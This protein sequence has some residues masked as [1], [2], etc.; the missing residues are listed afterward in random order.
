MFRRALTTCSIVV[1]LVAQALSADD[2]PEYRLAVQLVQE[3]RWAEALDHIQNLR[4]QYPGNPKV[5]NLE[6]LALLGRGDSGGAAAAFERVLVAHPGF[7]P[8]IKN[9]AILEWETKNRRAAEHTVQA[10]KMEPKDPVLNVYGALSALEQK[11]ASA[12]NRH[13]DLAGNAISAMPPQLEMRL[14]YL[15][16]T[17]GSYARAAHVYEDIV[18]HG[19]R[20]PTLTY[21]FGLAQYLGGDYQGAIH[22]LEEP[23][24]Q[25]QSRDELNLLAQAYEKNHQTQLA[26]DRLR[27]A[28][29]RFPSDENN[30]LDLATICIDHN[31]YP[32]GIQ[33]V[34]LGLKSNPGSKKLLF[35]LGVLHALSG[36]FDVARDEFRIVRKLAP[37]QD[38][39]VAAL[40]LADI[41]QN[42]ETLQEL[43]RNLK[44]KGDSAILCY[45]LGSS[46]VRKGARRGTPEYAE[47]RRCFQ[48]AIQLDPKLPYPYIELGKMYEQ[49]GKIPEAISLFEKVTALGFRD[50]APYY[51]LAR[52]YQKLN[53][54]QKAKQMLKKL[55]E[56][57]R[58][59]REFEQVG[60][61]GPE[62]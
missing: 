14:A 62:A 4:K 7:F 18:A 23:G 24:S 26:I 15:L 10:L 32:L 11:N 19:A 51:H 3:Q 30:Y 43:R 33:I 59:S 31:A 22:T 5:G 44:E 42:E 46:L 49:A 53:Q 52:D 60:L 20:G 48:R 6:G 40:E 36:E 34:E 57:Q 58:Q 54:S 38:L 37:G 2:P 56:I 35:Q 47:A 12:A 27:E 55:K 28:I 16:G 61:T 39:P 9:I 45:V 25:E 1:L 17:T 13:L 41:Q 29:T 50:P 21:N 8:A